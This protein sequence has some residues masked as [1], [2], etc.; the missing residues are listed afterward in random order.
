MI[1][2]VI[3]EEKIQ[4]AQSYIEKGE[5]FAILTHISP[6]GD[7]LGASL[8][9]FHFLLSRGKECVSIIVPNDF[10]DFFSWMPG[11]DKILIYAKETELSDRM[12]AS[13]DVIFCL[14]FN[15]LN[16]IEKIAPTLIEAKGTKIMIDH[17]LHPGDFCSLI[18]SHPERSSTCEL[19]FRFFYRMG[20]L[21]SM[22]KT[23]ATCIYTGM[24]TDTGSFSYNSNQ[25][26]IYA[27]VGELLKKGVDK[28]WIYSQINQVYSESR[29]RM[30]GY[31][32]YKK[33]KVYP[34]K[35]AALITLTQEELACFNYKQGDTEGFSNLP[36]DMKNISFSV[37][38]REDKDYIKV[39]LRSIGD[40]PC[41]TFSAKYFNGGGHK[42]ASGGEVFGTMEDAIALFEKGLAEF[43]FNQ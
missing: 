41:N 33:M 11:A 38:L 17:H 19:M 36:L 24:M 30:M 20:Q 23:I 35:Q 26:E 10:P 9:L 8:S 39:S 43:D 28:D 27:I 3:Q 31:V 25:P 13:A 15:S 4:Q 14:D 12:I 16:R 6:D 5:R 40:V 2:K 21:E 7:A 29:L 34:E 22:D 32:L 37:F 1:T 18:M 42:N